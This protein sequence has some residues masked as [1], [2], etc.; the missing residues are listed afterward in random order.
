MCRCTSA[1]SRSVSF[2]APARR[3][4]SPRRTRRAVNTAAMA[5]TGR[6]RP[7][8]R[9]GSAR[10]CPAPGVASRPRT[11]ESAPHRYRRRVGGHEGGS[12]RGWGLLGGTVCS[13][14]PSSSSSSSAEPPSYPGATLLRGAA[15]VNH[16]LFNFQSPKAKSVKS[17][18]GEGE[19]WRGGIACPD[20]MLSPGSL[21]AQQMSVW[22]CG[23]MSGQPYCL[24]EP[25]GGKKKRKIEE[26]RP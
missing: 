11:R 22:S 14:P 24:G 1:E 3:K 16:K 23:S 5:A 9:C 18:C 17:R 12:E 19:G 21:G 6:G 13:P 20:P 4:K 7:W 25:L 8:G 2:T 10:P 15:V 26:P